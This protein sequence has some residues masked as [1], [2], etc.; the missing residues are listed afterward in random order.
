MRKKYTMGLLILCGL[1]VFLFNGCGKSPAEEVKKIDLSIYEK[2]DYFISPEE[3]K[4]LLGTENLVLLDCNNPKLYAKEHIK[5]AVGIGFHA[6]SEKVGK[7]G[8]PGWGTIK[9]KEEL[10]KKLISLGIDNEKIVVLYSDL[11]KGPGA[12]GRA[13]WQLRLAGMKNVKILH[14]GSGYWKELGYEMTNDVTVKPTPSTG[15]TLKD[16][17]R[18]FMV[19][20]DEIYKNLGKTTLIDVRTK[21]EFDGSQN[22]GEPR[23]GHIKGA[24]HLLWTDLLNKNGT[25]KTPK[26]MEEIMSEMGVSKKDDFT[27]Y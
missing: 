22:A 1:M 13:A 9:S 25:L 17:D 2:G 23:G 27:L 11:F 20:K 4:T 26:E 5:G 14:G 8:D 12:D 10:T 15:V 16:Y 18:S 21:K 19:T 7:P 3:L 6:F 24:K